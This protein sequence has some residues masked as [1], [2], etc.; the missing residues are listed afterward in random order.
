MSNYNIPATALTDEGKGASRRLHHAGKVP[1]V[2][3]GGGKEASSIEIEH[4]QLWN[5]IEDQKIFTSRVDLTVDGKAETVMFKDMQR[6]P[7]EA[8]VLHVD[9]MRVT[10]NSKIKK[11]IPLNVINAATAVGVKAGGLMTILMPTVELVGLAKD[12]PDQITVD[13]KDLDA[14]ESIRMSELALPEGIAVRALQ[15]G[16]RKNDHS[17]V[18]IG[19]ARK[20]R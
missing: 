3:Y 1:A 15:K 4:N 7:F 11:Q 14:G 16:G 19:K 20:A 6:H 2:I 18:L 12:M 17:V 5:K 9:F 13:V 8:R 10:D